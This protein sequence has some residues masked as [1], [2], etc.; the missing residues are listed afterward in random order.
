MFGKQRVKFFSNSSIEGA[1][2]DK[3]TKRSSWSLLGIALPATLVTETCRF[4][5][6][7]EVRLDPV[8]VERLGERILTQQLE[9]EVAPYGEIVSTLCTSRQRGDVLTVTLS[10]ECVEEIGERVPILTEESGS[11]PS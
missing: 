9:T 10:A 2:Y 7:A 6:T 8:R 1:N 5:E 11:G 4:Y 3:I